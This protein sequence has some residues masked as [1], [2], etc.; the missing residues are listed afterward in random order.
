MRMEALAGQNRTAALRSAFDAFSEQI[1]N[2]L[3]TEL[4]TETAELF[5][6]LLDEPKQAEAA[7]Q[8]DE[9]IRLCRIP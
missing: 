1:R 2:E 5:E 7:R 6:W 3:G 8:P 4:T 9:Q